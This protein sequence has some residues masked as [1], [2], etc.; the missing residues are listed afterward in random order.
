MKICA[1]KGVSVSINEISSYSRTGVIQP[2]LYV[3]SRPVFA[4][5]L[6][7]NKSSAV[8]LG[9]CL[10][11]AHWD[12]GNEMIAVLDNLSRDEKVQVDIKAPV[13]R[14]A[15]TDI[16]HMS[17]SI[18]PETFRRFTQQNL[19]L[20]R[21]CDDS[22]IQWYLFEGL[23]FNIRMEN[24]FISAGDI[25]KLLLQPQKTSNANTK[26]QRMKLFKT[27]IEKII[28]LV[29][30]SGIAIQSETLPSTK[31]TWIEIIVMIEP[32]LQ[33]LSTSVNGT[34]EDYFDD[35]EYKFKPGRKKKTETDLMSKIRSLVSAQNLS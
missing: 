22:N 16:Q 18:E 8:I 7:E 19:K 31:Q 3:D 34:L 20:Q 30:E 29:R 23:Q 25:D 28:T 24:I 11:S 1:D 17:W 2:I 27:A 9:H 15:M 6:N 12:L 10:L 35:T 4:C 5:C 14:F 26:L 32:S 21:V 13:S 33:V